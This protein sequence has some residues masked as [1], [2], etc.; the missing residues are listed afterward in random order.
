MLFVGGHNV[1]VTH[2]RRQTAAIVE[3]SPNLRTVGHN[4]LSYGADTMFHRTHF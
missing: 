2:P 4:G 1:H 3:K